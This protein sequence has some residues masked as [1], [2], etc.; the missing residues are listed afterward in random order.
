MLRMSKMDGITHNSADGASGSTPATATPTRIVVHKNMIFPLVAGACFSLGM[1]LGSYF[2][3]GYGA[4]PTAL[5]VGVVVGLLNALFANE[6]LVVT[7]NLVTVK[8]GKKWPIAGLSDLEIDSKKRLIRRSDG[9]R[10]ANI[11]T[12]IKASDRRALQA[13]ID[14]AR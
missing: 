8:H 3:F 9:K 1:I 14:A 11:G 5:A 10:I 7:P 6:K 4:V 12:G 13:A 2:F